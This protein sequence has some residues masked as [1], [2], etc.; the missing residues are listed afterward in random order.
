MTASPL[1]SPP[2]LA[3]CVPILI[4]PYF[5]RTSLYP[6]AEFDVVGG[7][8]AD[9]N[10]GVGGSAPVAAAAASAAGAMA[11]SAVQTAVLAA[12]PHKQL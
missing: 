1:L 10:S 11:A 8:M 12:H 9:S 2:Q 7:A 3:V 5:T 6:A 4:A